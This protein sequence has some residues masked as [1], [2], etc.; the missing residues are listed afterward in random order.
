MSVQTRLIG[1]KTV[2]F[3]CIVEISIE[4]LSKWTFKGSMAISKSCLFY[5]SPYSLLSMVGGGWLNKS[6]KRKLGELKTADKEKA[7]LEK[8]K[9]NTIR[10]KVELLLIAISA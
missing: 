6:C 1:I 3:S 7:Q 5:Y 8:S 10:H 2:A 4:E 9:I